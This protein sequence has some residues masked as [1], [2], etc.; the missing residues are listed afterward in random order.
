[1]VLLITGNSCIFAI[2]CMEN[3]NLAVNVDDFELLTSFGTC[4]ACALAD[5]EL[6]YGYQ[7]SCR[8]FDNY[9]SAVFM[10]IDGVP[11]N[12]ANQ[13]LV[14]GIANTGTEIWGTKV[15]NNEIYLQ[16]HYKFVNN[17]STGITPDTVEYEMIANNISGNTHSISLMIMIDT[18]VNGK[19]GATISTDDGLTTLGNNTIYYKSSIMPPDWWDYDVDPKNGT[20]NLVGRGHLFNNPFCDPATEPDI[21]VVGNWARLSCLLG[22]NFESGL[23]FDMPWS[24]VS[25]SFS[26]ND[27]TEDSAV[28]LWWTNGNGGDLSTS[29]ALPSGQ[30]LTWIAYY[31]LN[32]GVLLATPTISA[33]CTPSPTISPTPS[34]TPTYTITP[35]FTQTPVP[36]NLRG[37]FPNIFHDDVNII[38]WLSR[39][40]TVKLTIYDVSGE[41]VL[42]QSGIQGTKGNNKFYWNGKNQYGRPIASGIYIY[43]IEAVTELN[44]HA[45]VIAKL[46]HIR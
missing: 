25:T 9:T 5:A 17:P 8:M 37:G 35:T 39:N 28:E 20:P 30:S 26:I 4:D 23:P 2:Q 13:N 41:V 31:G 12:I 36:L 16:L 1:M 45:K 11:C 15:I 3:N 18:E 46:A 29:Y 6:V 44:E 34:I 32:Q 22:I 7:S 40:A 33:T 14:G 42:T 10:N 43:E 21:F 24:L 27:P 38:F 19:D